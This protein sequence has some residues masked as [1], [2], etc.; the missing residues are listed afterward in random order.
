MEMRWKTS[1]VSNQLMNRFM[2]FQIL[3]PRVKLF[4]IGGQHLLLYTVVRDSKSVR[5]DEV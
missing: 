3:K 2:S 4:P 1:S 5:D